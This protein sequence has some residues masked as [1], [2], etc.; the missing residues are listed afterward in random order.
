MRG[1]D[2][3]GGGG[4]GDDPDDRDKSSND[5]VRAEYL[6]VVL[7]PRG[8]YS[9]PQHRAV[10]IADLPVADGAAFPVVP[11]ASEAIV[12][13]REEDY[14]NPEAV[15]FQIMQIQTPTR[16]PKVLPTVETMYG[17]R[18]TARLSFLVQWY[19]RRTFMGPELLDTVQVYAESDPV[20][21]TCFDL[22]PFAVL[23]KRLT[24]WRGVGVGEEPGSY[25]LSLPERAKPHLPL[26][27]EKCPAL[28]FGGAASP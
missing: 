27:D 10:P 28:L 18:H 14:R 7:Q 23:R 1:F 5:A 26:Q 13:A 11:G 17:T 15:Y 9:H 25:I 19:D 20:W 8:Y 24:I 22:A 2:G 21:T 16:K 3:G 4:G 12:V 6:Q